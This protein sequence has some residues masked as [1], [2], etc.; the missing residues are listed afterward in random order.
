MEKI[1]LLAPAGSMES[2][3]AA[4]T[5]GADAIYLG[6]SKFSARAYAS[7]F[8]NEQME[9][10]VDYCHEYGVTVYVTVNTLIKENEF[11]E[12]MDYIG[13]L[14][15]IG[16][17]ALIIQDTGLVN[18]IREDYPDFEIH[19]STQ[20]TI[21]NGEGALFFR[22]NGFLR[23]VLSRE[24]TLKEVRYISKE[25]NIETEIFVHGALCV[26]YSG[27]CLMSSLIGGRSGNRGRCA[28]SCRLPYTL[29]RESDG[30]EI[31]GYLLSPKDT[32]MIENVEDL[33]NSGTSSLKVEGRMKR[34]EYVAG[35]T[36]SYRE[37][38]DNVYNKI[39]KS[40]ENNKKKL[41]RLFNREGFSTAYLYKNIGGDMM[42]YKNPK[43]TGVF[44]GQVLK[45]GEILLSDDIALQDGI[46][47]GDLGFTVTKI[48]L[49]GTEVRAAKKGSIVKVLPRKYKANDKLFKTS[50]SK[51]LD[52]LKVAYEN[53]FERKILLH[54]KFIF[55][56][57]EPIE[58]RVLYNGK[59]Y[60]RQGDIVESAV[61][62]PVS[63]EKVE[64]NLKKSGD[65]AY[66]IDSIEFLDF[67]DG[68]IKISSINNLRREVLE[69]IRAFEVLRFKR[70]E[71]RKE[72]KE[73]KNID[74]TIPNIL[75]G[76]NTYEQLKA[77]KEKRVEAIALDVF[78]K[79]KGA[80]NKSS[81][82][83][84]EDFKGDIYL[85]IPT[86][87]KEE[88]GIICSFISKNLE[89]ISGIVTANAGIINR[90][91][92]KTKI[93]GDYK[94][95]IFNSNS[96]KFYNK[97]IAASCISI[98][99]NRK[100]IKAML[101]KYN[102]GIQFFLYGKIEAMVSEY[103]PIGSTF[104]GKNTTKSCSSECT[105]STF[106][107]KD[108]VGQD[109][110]IKTDIFCRSHI[111]NTVAINLISDMEDI[112]S[113][114]IESFRVDFID[115]DYEETLKVINAITNGEK[116]VGNYTKGHFRRGVE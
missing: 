84:L 74:R 93:I 60:K 63:K 71:T 96:L 105:K 114:G 77:V 85:K 76:I 82:E 20:L 115:E 65:I 34:P 110:A 91:K 100:E 116:L 88:F 30:K 9:K 22:D 4:V 72:Y 80:L 53:K 43:N 67:E 45:S 17:D 16:V 48:F 66:K 38:I 37:A 32:C 2:L 10:A 107:L 109:N 98:E 1:E 95:N 46:T 11:Q 41:L 58:L 92:D 44:L 94:L 61:N 113:M 108:R 15:R 68:F 111:Y 59:E 6:G 69:E 70:N 86:I 62:R 104:G 81:L 7:N 83:E 87:I 56:V 24:L 39:N 21:H 50:D 14:Y 112:K 49:N 52:S 18:K 35:V 73:I 102:R 26:C 75:I 101:K 40:Q 13:F 28:Q 79:N 78:G 12:A 19:A 54:G 97:H 42:A 51:L 27:Q 103:C 55:K 8:D 29:I 33:I 47:N 89:K 5:K 31:K 25:L 57:G 64:D 99:L 23:I 36:E 90:F 3:V 106:I